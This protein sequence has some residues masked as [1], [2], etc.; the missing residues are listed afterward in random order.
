M[1]TRDG[2]TSPWLTAEECALYMNK[3]V[4]KVNA[5]VRSG[6]LDSRAEPDSKRGVLIHVSKVDAMIDGWPSGAKIPP[7]MQEAEIT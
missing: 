4:N 5:W 6:A 7:E 3:S 2:V 1:V